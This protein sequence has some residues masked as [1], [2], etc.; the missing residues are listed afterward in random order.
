MPVQELRQGW[1]ARFGL[2][3]RWTLRIQRLLLSDDHEGDLPFGGMNLRKSPVVMTVVVPV[4][5]PEGR[6]R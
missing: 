1:G 5:R 2:P 6:C 4:N 3:Y